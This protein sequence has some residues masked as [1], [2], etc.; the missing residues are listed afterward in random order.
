MEDWLLFYIEARLE[1]DW[2][3]FFYIETRL[4]LDWLLFFIL[5]LA[6]N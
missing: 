1:L 4:E 6:W 5:S 3:L 2:L